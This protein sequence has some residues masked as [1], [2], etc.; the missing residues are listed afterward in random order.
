M[1]Y[2]PPHIFLRLPKE[3]RGGPPDAGL[4][5]RYI[6]M[7]QV[8]IQRSKTKLRMTPANSYS[9]SLKIFRNGILLLQ[10]NL[11]AGGLLEL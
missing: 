3:V 11:R 8:G 6:R 4:Y 5:P 7:Y 10:W 9:W 2:T 1:K